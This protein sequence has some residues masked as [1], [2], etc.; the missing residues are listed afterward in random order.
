MTDDPQPLDDQLGGPEPLDFSALTDLEVFGRWAEVMRELAARGLIW[1]GKSPLADYAELLVA[2][3]F[4]VEP[5]K[6][7]NPGFDLVTKDDRRV[8]VES[9]RYGPGS[10][11]SH[12]GEFSEFEQVRFDDLAVVLFEEDFTVREA[13]LAPY[14]WVAERA[15]VVKGKHRLT[16][17]AVLDDKDNLTRLK[18]DQS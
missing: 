12:F 14:G 17:K 10:K 11:P 6:G 1:S 9:R 2:R 4:G 7:S 5:V 18:L 3:Y 16:I 15:K 8:Q 13:Y